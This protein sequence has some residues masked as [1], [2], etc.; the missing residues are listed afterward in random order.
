MRPGVM[1]SRFVGNTS[2]DINASEMIWRFF[3]GR[4]LR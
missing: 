1:A 3:K 2:Y 4:T